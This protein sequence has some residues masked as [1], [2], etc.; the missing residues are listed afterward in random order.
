MLFVLSEQAL[1]LPFG[2]CLNSE[3]LDYRWGYILDVS[4][5]KIHCGI[6]VLA[7][8]DHRYSHI[9]GTVISVGSV[10]SSVVCGDDNG[11][12]V[13]KIRYKGNTLKGRVENVNQRAI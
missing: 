10:M 9:L 3:E 2:L 7:E 1:A 13:G 6:Y 11:I 8:Y 5:L 12:I 4:A